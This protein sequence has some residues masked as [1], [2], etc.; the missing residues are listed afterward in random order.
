MKYGIARSWECLHHMLISVRAP[1]SL[2][3]IQ[4]WNKLWKWSFHKT[5]AE[6]ASSTA[7]LVSDS[8]LAHLHRSWLDCEPAIKTISLR[9][10]QSIREPRIILNED[11]TSME[12][13][14]PTNNWREHATFSPNLGDTVSTHK[15]RTRTISDSN[16]FCFYLYPWSLILV[17]DSPVPWYPT[18]VRTT[19][20][21]FLTN[22]IYCYHGMNIEYCLRRNILPILIIAT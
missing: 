10:W 7:I 11:C 20:A 6:L 9:H 8:R 16:S 4:P 15:R 21:F 22:K 18:P 12:M 5:V 2:G 19:V 1:A 3:R 13:E 14:C 17:L